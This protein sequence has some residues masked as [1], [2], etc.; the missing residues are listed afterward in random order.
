M[1]NDYHL[2]WP[3]E[4]SVVRPSSERGIYF[5]LLHGIRHLQIDLDEL[6]WNL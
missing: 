4:G 2:R 1:R 6:V 5:W 3:L